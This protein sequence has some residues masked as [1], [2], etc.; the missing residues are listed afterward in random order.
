MEPITLPYYVVLS[1]WCKASLTFFKDES[2]HYIQFISL[3]LYTIHFVKT[4]YTSGG[5]EAAGWR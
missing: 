3:R 2:I 4:E 5:K 1:R